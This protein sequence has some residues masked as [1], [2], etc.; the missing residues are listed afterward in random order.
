MIQGAVV[1]VWQL[2]LQLPMQ[3][4]HIATN[5]VSS[6]PT[7]AIRHYVKQ[8]EYTLENTKGA[9]RKGQ[10]RETGNIGYTR[11]YHAQ[12]QQHRVHK[13]RQTKQKH[14]TI[15]LGHQYMQTNANKTC[16]LLQSK[17]DREFEPRSSQNKDCKN[18]FCYVSTQHAA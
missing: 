7:Q 9:I 14:N 6:N 12:N 10:S 8:F 3:S 2:D 13:G 4:V 18:C 17:V 5:V 15:F 11:R 16:T 1:V